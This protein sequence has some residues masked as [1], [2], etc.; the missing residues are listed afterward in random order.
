[1][2]WLR[3]WDG[4]DSDS[5]TS[6]EIGYAYATGKPIV[7]IRTDIREGAGTAGPNNAMLA[8][9]PT[10]RVDMPAASTSEVITAILEA[11]SRLADAGRTVRRGGGGSTS[12][13]P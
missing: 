5:G 6:W 12:R 2:G 10:I 3:S 11:L 4:S 8:E 1:M 9:S 13:E 7:L